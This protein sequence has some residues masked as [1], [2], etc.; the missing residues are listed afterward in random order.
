MVFDNELVKLQNLFKKLQ[1]KGLALHHNEVMKGYA[2][3]AFEGQNFDGKSFVPIAIE[4]GANLIITAK[5]VSYNYNE[6]VFF[7]TIL[8][9]KSMIG[10]IA[11]SFYSYIPSDLTAITGTNG[12][13]SSCYFYVQIL[14]QLGYKTA[15]IG[16]LGLFN[17]HELLDKCFLT[18]PNII[19]LRRNLQ[20]L[21]KQN[22]QKV[23][24]EASSH[25]LHQGRLNTLEFEKVAFT[26]FTQD[27]LDYHI[28]MKAYL[29]AKL[30]IFQPHVKKAVI[31]RDTDNYTQ[32]FKRIENLKIQV[33]T[34]GCH[35]ESD[36]RLI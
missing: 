26:N 18:T 34:F 25:G 5:P 11:A 27:H 7:Y 16:T 14:S 17:G 10:E 19:N 15:L 30:Q 2:F 36:L 6:K 22:Y 24:I 23:I 8:N 3:L 1:I 31:N 28:N 13:T 9:L 12:K 32:I 4:K 33:I 29:E 21:A 20:L 35:E